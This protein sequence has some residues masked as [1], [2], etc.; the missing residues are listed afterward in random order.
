M[1]IAL[2]CDYSLDYLGGA[3]SAFCEQVQA[4]QEAGHNVIVIAPLGRRT[5]IGAAKHEWIETPF[6][7]P[8]IDLPFVRN[9]SRIRARITQILRREHV[10]I[11]HIHSEFGLAAACIDAARELQ[12]PVVHTVHTFFWQAN[13]PGV[14]QRIAAQAIR[15]FHSWLTGQNSPNAYLPYP[16]VDVALRKMTLSTALRVS[17]VISPSEHQRQ[18]L[19]AAGVPHVVTIPNTTTADIR[20][21]P[22]PLSHIDGPLRVI[23]I[24]RC[25]PEKR[26][27]TFVA[28]CVQALDSTPA[29]ALTVEIVGDGPLLAK[30]R[31]IATGRDEISFSGRVPSDEVFQKLAHAH[32][33][34][35]TSSGFDNQPMTVV[36]ALYASRPVL[37]VDPDLQEG[38]DTAGILCRDDS[39]DSIAETLTSLA[40]DRSQV[41][42][43]SQRAND[44]FDRFSPSHFVADI[45]RVYQSVQ[46]TG[47]RH[48]TEGISISTSTFANWMG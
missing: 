42:R 5:T 35:L 29:D 31:R 44:A 27:L 21:R 34:A 17:A 14:L 13:L 19:L 26:L 38:L 11:V 16:Q 41:S 12:T 22:D 28:A 7:I 48:A 8:G 9:T 37:Y 4:L 30:A 36:E 24:G 46:P 47:H 15:S 1:N 39:I 2:V 32:I 43:A 25:V 6:T 45:E 33:A 40:L 3:Q 10:D 20:N 23:W 18:L